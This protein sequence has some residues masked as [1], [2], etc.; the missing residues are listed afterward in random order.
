VAEPPVVG[1]GGVGGAG[2]HAAA[3]AN[4]AAPQYHRMGVMGARYILAKTYDKTTLTLTKAV[5]RFVTLAPRADRI[6]GEGRSE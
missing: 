3:S 4:A 6:T 5:R 1:D 2:E